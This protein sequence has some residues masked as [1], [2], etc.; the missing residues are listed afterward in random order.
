[1]KYKILNNLQFYFKNDFVVVQIDEKYLKER[2]HIF[3]VEDHQEHFLEVEEVGLKKGKLEIVYVRPQGYKPLVDLTEYANFYKLDIVNSLLELDVLQHEKTYLSMTN[4]LVKDTK[5]ILLVYKADKFNNLP[6]DKTN[7]LDMYKNFICSFFGKYSLEKYSKNRTEILNKEK[8]EFLLTIDQ[9][10]NLEE[11]RHLIAYELTEEQQNFFSEELKEKKASQKTVRRKR[12]VKLVLGV[13]VCA[14]YVGTVVTLKVG[15]KKQV[16]AIQKDN[17]TEI[18][19][20]NK[21]ISNDSKDLEADMKKMNY[22]KKKQVDI[23]LKLND[24]K[25][26]YELDKKADTKIVTSL[27]KQG[28]IEEIKKLDLPGSDYV[29]SFKE[30]LDYKEFSDVDYL[31]QS[32]NEITLIEAIIDQAITK[33]DTTTLDTVLTVSIDQKGLEIEPNY[34]IKLIDTLIDKNNADLEAL[35][36]N[37]TVSE[38]NKKNQSSDLIEANN[39]L[40]ERKIELSKAIGKN[41]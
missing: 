11:L 13:L 5:N 24:Y 34:Q 36:K 23:Y 3:D 9:A 29:N 4:I 21:I 32:T 1:M 39:K 27:Y 14:L 30:V 16:S 2:E 40:L 33:N 8:N 15:E 18:A 10:E 7:E 26:A 41:S 38:D 6:H 28:K 31:V 20:L 19:I 17:E 37:D 25:K 12:R 35:Y 22:P